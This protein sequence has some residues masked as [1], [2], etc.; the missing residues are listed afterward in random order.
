[1]ASTHEDFDHAS[2]AGRISESAE[3]AI[4]KADS[5][6]SS[7]LSDNLEQSQD[8]QN[9]SLIAASP[10]V[11]PH[12]LCLYHKMAAVSCFSSPRDFNRN[13]YTETGYTPKRFRPE[14]YEAESS[15]GRRH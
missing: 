14:E 9:P 2:V 13:P 10:L 11:S 7:S 4:A 3:T 15:D 1:M 12:P 5:S 6:Y 8:L